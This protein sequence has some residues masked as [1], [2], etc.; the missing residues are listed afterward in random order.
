MAGFLVD[1]DVP[2]KTIIFSGMVMMISGCLAIR[3][4]SAIWAAIMLS[5]IDFGSGLTQV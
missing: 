4:S 5:V 2:R 3:R 1:K